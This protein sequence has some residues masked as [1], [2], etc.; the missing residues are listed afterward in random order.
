MIPWRNE[1]R[2]LKPALMVRQTPATKMN[3]AMYLGLPGGWLN[4][5]LEQNWRQLVSYSNEDVCFFCSQTKTM[6]PTN[7]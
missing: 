3:P 5:M 6:L 7:F 4:H 2:L 1:V